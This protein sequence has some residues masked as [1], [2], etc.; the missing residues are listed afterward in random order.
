[1]YNWINV[2]L[3]KSGE[4]LYK[5]SNFLALKGKLPKCNWWLSVWFWPLEVFIRCGHKTTWR[6]SP[7]VSKLPSPAIKFKMHTPLNLKNAF[8]KYFPTHGQRQMNRIF[9]IIIY[10][11]L[12]ER[13]EAFLLSI[14]R[15][16]LNKIWYLCNY[17][18]KDI[19]IYK[20]GK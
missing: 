6:E 13:L 7:R 20:I 12:Y 2:V 19:S 4:F 10:C 8:I 18:F 14:I 17:C 5:I 16:L 11:L 15:A 3:F 1:M 9:F